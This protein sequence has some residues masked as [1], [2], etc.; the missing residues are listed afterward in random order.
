MKSLSTLFIIILILITGCQKR[1]R[2][3]TPIIEGR[4]IIS[5]HGMVVSAHPEASRIGAAVLRKGGNAVDAA[6]ATGFALA[7]C[8]PEAGNI[9]GGGFM[10]IRNNDGT[11]DVIDYREKAPS[12]A[13]REMYLSPDGN[14]IAG[15]STETHLAAGVPGSVDGMIKVHSRYGKLRFRKIIQPAINLAN[16]GFPVTSGQAASLNRNRELFIS[17]NDVRP[18]FIRD[19]L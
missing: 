12:G 13:S 11:A 10:V 6:V 9:G 2:S 18:A 3:D 16:Y 14:T 19:S 5:R 17:K 4:N 15:L 8:Y 1:Q 7:V